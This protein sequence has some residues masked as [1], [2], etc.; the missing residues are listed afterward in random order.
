MAPLSRALL[1][2]REDQLRVLGEARAAAETG[3]GRLVVVEGPAGMGKSAVLAAERDHLRRHGKLVLSARCSEL[4]STYAFGVVR[5]LFEPRLHASAAWLEGSAG[6]AA[7]VFDAPTD[8]APSGFEDDVSHS[9]LHGLYWLTAN[10]CADRFVALVVDDAQWCDRPSL[11]FLAYLAGRLDGMSVLLVVA[12]RT[13]DRLEPLLADLAHEDPA[14]VV[15]LEPLSLAGVASLLAERLGVAPRAEFAQA[16]LRATGGNPLLLDE[17]SRAMRTDGIRPDVAPLDVLADVGPR[18]VSRTVLLRL[19]RL[20]ANAIALAQAVAILGDAGD[21]AILG[22]MTGL[23]SAAL[24]QAARSLVHAQILRSQSPMGF[25]HPLLRD[26]VYQDLSPIEREARHAEAARLLHGAGRSAEQIAAHALLLPPAARPWIVDVLSESAAVAMSRGAPDI[27]VSYL[28]RALAEPAGPELEPTLV[29]RLGMAEALANAPQE[30]VVHL[31]AG[32]ASS[33]DPAARGRIAAVLARMLLFTRPP[34]EAVAVARRARTQLPP[35][36]ADQRDALVAL[37][38]YAV[39][40]GATDDEQAAVATTPAAGGPGARM[41]AAVRAW[42]RALT[43]GSAARCVEEA[44]FALGD[45]MLVRHDPSFMTHVAAGVL[46][47][48]DDERALAVWS[49]AMAEGHTHGSQMTIAGVLLWQ[50]WGWLQRGALAEA[51]ESLRRYRVAVQRRGGEREAGAAYGIG[52]LTR[53]L[54]ARGELADARRLAELPRV[55]TAGSDGDLQQVRGVV[56]VLLADGRWQTALTALDEVPRR[57]RPVVNP[58]WAPWG[59]LAARAL[60]G[61]GRTE[62]ALTRAAEE[63]AAA[64]AWGAP[65]GVG[66]A[67]R[68]LGIAYDVAGSAD[69]QP[70]FEEAV[71]VTEGSPARL[72]HAASLLAHGSWLRRGR[73]PTLARSPLEH[74]AGLARACGATP[75]ADRATQEFRAAGGQRLARNATGVDALTPSERRVAALAASGR[76]NKAIAQELFVTTKTVEV[77]LSNTYRKLGVVSRADLAGLVVADD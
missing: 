26:A 43:G 68:A 55:S 48:A 57:R 25:V 61:L 65:T 52:F 75:L 19:A 69:A 21:L 17:L 50:G 44:R 41:L 67:L 60:C 45:G 7:A 2:E 47:L 64:R 8:A 72:E 66:A 20:D 30:A 46:A 24:E 31:G 12:A 3:V 40:F 18:A 71:A 32:Y 9:V 6:S 35:E 33:T 23:P 62:E 11:R 39:A 76:S 54:V 38:L 27:A 5:Q 37:E 58:V 42:D 36:L 34:D 4:E 22:G 70:A 51:E 15:T 59:S 14:E 73:Q 1:V 53:T 16:C 77:H 28:R 10:A 74:A 13:G 29:T 56:E 49:Q 63:V